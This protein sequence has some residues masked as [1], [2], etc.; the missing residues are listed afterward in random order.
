VGETR[1]KNPLLGG[2]IESQTLSGWVSLYPFP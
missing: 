1:R 2:A